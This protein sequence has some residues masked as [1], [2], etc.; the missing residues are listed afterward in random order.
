LTAGIAFDLTMHMDDMKSNLITTIP[1]YNGQEFI[2]QTLQSV[3]KQTLRPDR[4][5][6]LDNCSNDRTEEIVK[7]FT[8]V[9][10]E[11]V[12]NPKNLGVLGNCNRCLEFAAE[13]KYLNILHAD[14]VLEPAYYEVMTRALENC[15]GRGMAYCLDERID[16]N[17]R[18]LSVSGRV[19]GAVEQE[20]K[21]KFLSGKAEI[22]NQAFS[23]TLLKTNYQAAPCQ[24]RLDFPILADMVYWSEWGTHCEQIIK[25]HQPL[26]KYRW[27]G[28]NVTTSLA[29]SIQSLILDEWRA[30]QTIEAM[31]GREPGAVRRL[32]LKGLFAVRSG[33]KAKRIRQNQKNPDYSKQ[34]VGVTREV[35]GAPLWLA[36]Q[37]VVEFR[38]LVVYKILGRP[39]HP[40]NVYS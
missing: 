7:G 17:N 9:K 13:T 19:T 8:G 14:D 31:R 37:L 2:L 1:V 22:G 39:Q 38:D 20:S 33:I 15:G 23:G 36:G 32:K 40:K 16:E 10:C 25:V 27:H 11:W 26:A 28:T 12:R 29:P 6:V 34:I 21:D 30:M 24:F 3:A 18:R 5:V 4:V 35:T